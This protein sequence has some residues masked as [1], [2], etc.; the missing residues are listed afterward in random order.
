M[1]EVP[2]TT[3]IPARGALTHLGSVP[4]WFAAVDAAGRYFAAVER[5]TLTVYALVPDLPSVTSVQL[6]PVQGQWFFPPAVHLDGTTIALLTGDGVLELWREG[7][8]VATMPTDLADSPAMEGPLGGPGATCWLEFTPDGSGLLF[9]C[10]GDK[11]DDPARI[12]LLDARTLAVRDT[13]SAP[14]SGYP[15]H[16]GATLINWSEGV[17]TAGTAS[18]AIGVG[19]MANLGD[20]PHVLAVAEVDGD[21]LHVHGAGFDQPFAPEVFGE[22]LCEIAFCGDELLAL[23]SD[24]FISAW[25]WRDDKPVRRTVAKSSRVVSEIYGDPVDVG[26]LAGTIAAGDDWIAA[27]VINEEGDLDVIAFLEPASGHCTGVLALPDPWRGRDT[28]I[29]NGFLARAVN[30]RIDV[31]TWTP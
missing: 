28:R 5:K 27:G 14:L 11:D 9:G 19:F 26:R 18:P 29:G 7:I 6:V 13:T 25:R 22:R 21:R 31:A 16:E 17:S 10:V 24:R 20:D 30:G 12:Y 2:T 3:G 4:G 1:P 8:R 23:D 15:H